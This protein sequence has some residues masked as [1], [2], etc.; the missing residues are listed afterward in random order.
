MRRFLGVLWIH[1]G[2]CEMHFNYKLFFKGVSCSCFDVALVCIWRN[3]F[4][5]VQ[6]ILS[7]LM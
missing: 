1:A 2:I 6:S 5:Q 3:L 7:I 4:I